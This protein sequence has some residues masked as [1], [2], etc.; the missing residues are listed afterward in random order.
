MIRTP[1]RLA[2]VLVLMSGIAGAQADNTTFS[3]TLIEAPPCK[4]SNNQVID[5]NF[6]NVGINRVDGVNYRKDMSYL[7]TCD[8]VVHG[9]WALTLTLNGPAFASDSDG[10]AL[11]TDR[12]DLGIKVYEGGHPFKLNTPLPITPGNPPLLQVVPVKVP[13]TELPEGAFQATATLVAAF[14]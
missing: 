12:H 7:I 11:S 1:G 5:V 4:I 13:G 14:Q 6:G 10:A 3:G 8:P 2:L 9:R